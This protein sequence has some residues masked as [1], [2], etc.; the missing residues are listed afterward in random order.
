MTINS[1]LLHLRDPLLAIERAAGRARHQLVITD[2]AER[3]FAPVMPAELGS[4][5]LHFIPRAANG[6][7]I[8]GWWYMPSTL[9]IEQM[10]IL[11]FTSIEIRDFPLPF[12]DGH[13]WEFYTIVGT[14]A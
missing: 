11:G 10:R 6:G 2:V 4:H 13:D 14:R 3:Q 1:V 12:Q 8:D 7:P 5:C 9:I